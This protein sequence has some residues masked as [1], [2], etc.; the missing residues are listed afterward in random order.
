MLQ[1]HW[2]MPCAW[3][4]YNFYSG[5]PLCAGHKAVEPIVA[6]NIEPINMPTLGI[7]RGILV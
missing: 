2:L 4:Q 5:L 3:S 7:G 1:P 6:A